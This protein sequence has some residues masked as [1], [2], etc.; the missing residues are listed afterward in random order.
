MFRTKESLENMS[1]YLLHWNLKYQRDAKMYS[2]IQLFSPRK[3]TRKKCRSCPQ[4][5]VHYEGIAK[6]K[7]GG[8][9]TKAV[10]CYTVQHYSMRLPLWGKMLSYSDSQGS[11]IQVS[12]GV[13]H[14]FRLKHNPVSLRA[15]KDVQN[16]ITKPCDKE[17]TKP[18]GRGKR[19]NASQSSDS[20]PKTFLLQAH[21]SLQ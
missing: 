15:S 17:W 16:V 9:Q 13:F 12:L 11:R 3:D 1:V 7:K 14:S 10:Y 8:G 4:K 21:L 2:F 5:N 19:L 18:L 6:L 20:S